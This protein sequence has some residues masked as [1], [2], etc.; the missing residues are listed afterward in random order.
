MLKA[1]GLSVR[2]GR[3]HG[4][5]RRSSG[6]PG[7]QSRC[8]EGLGGRH[9]GQG[10]VPD[11]P[12]PALRPRYQHHA[13]YRRDAVRLMHGKARLVS[14][15]QWAVVANTHEA[16]IGAEQWER[17]RSLLQRDTRTLNF[18][19]NVSP[20]CWVPGLRRLRMG[21][22]QD[23]RSGRRVLLLICPVPASFQ[24]KCGR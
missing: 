7:Y 13:V 11:A 22:E 8:V 19:G 9:P 14:K 23:Q 16:I 4:P 10:V 1:A 18:K 15:D 17:V 5:G 2:L 21:H 24:E 3:K 20:L 12:G 6:P